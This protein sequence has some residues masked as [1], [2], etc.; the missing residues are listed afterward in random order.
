[1]TN[2]NQGRSGEN[3][4]EEQNKEY[5]RQGKHAKGKQQSGNSGNSRQNTP[6]LSEKGEHVIAH[7]DGWAVQ[8]EN[9]SQPTKVFD[10]KDEAIKRAK[11][12]AGNKGG[13]VIIH[14]QDGTIQEN[15][16]Y[17]N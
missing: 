4:T 2:G 3:R 16:S 11:E 14:K 12:I 10:K 9:S 17:S 6:D 7:E 1:M 13:S 15:V 5:G 8:G